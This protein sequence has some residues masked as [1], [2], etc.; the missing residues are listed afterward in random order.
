ME[1]KGQAL[2][3]ENNSIMQSFI[4]GLKKVY[5]TKIKG[6]DLTKM[7]VATL[8]FEVS[9]QIEN[10][11]RLDDQIKP[12][13]LMMFEGYQGRSVEPRNSSIRHCQGIRVPLIS[14]E[15]KNFI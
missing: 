4:D 12:N 9:E 10:E 14:H 8:L 2:K 1:K 5:V 13:W 3:P 6:Y 15:P 7:C 11:S